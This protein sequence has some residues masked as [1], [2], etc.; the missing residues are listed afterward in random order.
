MAFGCQT[1]PEYKE[2]L[3]TQKIYE[4]LN[5]SI[6]LLVNKEENIQEDMF[7]MRM[8]I[9]YLLAVVKKQNRL[10]NKQ[11]ESQNNGLGA[12]KNPFKESE[13]LWKEMLGND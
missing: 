1:T 5:S 4:Q 12:Q 6:N 13:H 11:I 2:E 9:I 10:Q 3:S 7:L 8:K